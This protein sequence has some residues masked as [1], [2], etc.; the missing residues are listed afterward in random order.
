VEGGGGGSGGRRGVG[1][2]E[3]RRQSGHGAVV[4]GD[5]GK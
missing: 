5:A 3:L 1:C 4:K 2:G